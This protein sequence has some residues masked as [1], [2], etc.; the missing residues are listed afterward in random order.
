MVGGHTTNASVPITYLS[1][2]SRD[3]VRIAL[4]IATLNGLEILACDIQND[5]LTAEC[6]ELILTTAG[7]EFGLEEDVIMVV[8]MALYG[9]KPSGAVF[10]AKLLSL[11]H[12]IKYTPYTADLD[13]WMRPA[14]K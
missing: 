8:K 10:I 7:P 1:L 2:V 3:S 5:Y 9:L 11:L 4:T 6:M 12:D 14:I 13:V